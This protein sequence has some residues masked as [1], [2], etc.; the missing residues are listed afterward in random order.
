MLAHFW[1]LDLNTYLAGN[2]KYNKNTLKFKQYVL[3]YK[4]YWY[5]L[6]YTKCNIV[7]N[8]KYDA[9]SL[10]NARKRNY[11]VKVSPI[12]ASYSTLTN[13]NALLNDIQILLNTLEF[14]RLFLF[15]MSC[16]RLLMRD[17]L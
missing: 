15:D 16:F 7:T 17:M 12:Q 8:T 11:P 10:K 3:I 6:K 14:S 2:R 5:W 13:G 1:F 4:K 9:L